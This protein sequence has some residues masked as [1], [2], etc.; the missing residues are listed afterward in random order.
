MILYKGQRD[1]DVATMKRLL[2]E[3]QDGNR[4]SAFVLADAI[5]EKGYPKIA[6]AL[7]S[8]ASGTRNVKPEDIRAAVQRVLEK[9]EL[10]EVTPQQIQR[11]AL[12]VAKLRGQARHKAAMVL[13]D[14]AEGAGWPE[15]PNIIPTGRRGRPETWRVL[16]LDVWGNPR[17]GFEV[18]NAFT[19]GTIRVATEETLWNV[20]SYRDS[21]KKGFREWGSYHQPLLRAI[22]TSWDV[23]SDALWRALK[24]DYFAAATERR[25]I[26]FDNQGDGRIDVSL[27]RN[28]KP[29]LTLERVES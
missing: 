15:N 1:A 22:S 20:R 3:F 18:N 23:E 28:G 16:S 11:M 4:E 13:A 9:L 10:K 5:N 12:R 21:Y 27:A 29:L 25:H 24:R 26:E 17:D 6:Q 19:A 2:R 7:T 14:A 8:Y